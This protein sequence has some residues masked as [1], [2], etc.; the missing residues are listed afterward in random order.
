MEEKIQKASDKLDESLKEL[1]HISLESAAA[2]QNQDRRIIMQEFRLKARELVA[3]AQAA[4]QPPPEPSVPTPENYPFEVLI[5]EVAASWLGDRYYQGRK[6]NVSCDVEN[7]YNLQHRIAAGTTFEC[8][9]DVDSCVFAS[10]IFAG[11]TFAIKGG[12]HGL[13]LVAVHNSHFADFQIHAAP[14]NLGQAI[15]CTNNNKGKPASHEILFERFILNK[16]VRIGPINSEFDHDQPR[17]IVMQDFSMACPYTNCGIGIC[18]TDVLIRKAEIDFRK[19]DKAYC[20]G[21]SL[22]MVGQ[23]RPSKVYIEDLTCIVRA[24]QEAHCIPII[25]PCEAVVSRQNVRVMRG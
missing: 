25:D 12:K 23:Q 2:H 20:Y 7:C 17:A 4:V 15:K 24:D 9:D 19:W 3:E 6:P 1:Q 5:K 22:P 11:K 10:G 21:I 16:H 14:N 8:D 13:R 18:A